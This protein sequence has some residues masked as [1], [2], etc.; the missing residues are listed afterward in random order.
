MMRLVWDEAI[1]GKNDT[2]TAS[3]STQKFEMTILALGGV[4]KESMAKRKV[5][6]TI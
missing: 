2:M 6:L 5:K 4:A 3:R 1:K